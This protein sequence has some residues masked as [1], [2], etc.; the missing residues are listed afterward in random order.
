MARYRVGAG[1]L[2]VT[3][4]NGRVSVLAP[5]TVLDAIPLAYDGKLE[6]IDL[7]T[8]PAERK[9]ID[10]YADKRLSSDEDK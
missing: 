2:L 7:D 10:W 4:R 5:G 9:R 1:G 3:D 6:P 8:L